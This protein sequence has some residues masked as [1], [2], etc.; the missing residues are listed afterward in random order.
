MKTSPKTDILFVSHQYEI[1]GGGEKALLEMIQYLHKRGL[2]LHVIIG[3]PGS[4]AEELNKINVPHTIIF[5]PFWAHG[6]EDPSPFH[7]TSLNP[8]FN[9]TRQIVALIKQLN[10]RLCVTNTIVV[11]WLAYAS[12][13]TSK[14][15]AW[16]IHELGTAGL[17]LRYAIGE[18][19]T[20]RSIDL[21]S[22]II[23]FNSKYT[24]KYYL[25][26]ISP[27]TQTGIVYPGGNTPMPDT[28]SSPFTNKNAFKLV[29]VGQ[30]K[31]QKGQLD[32]VKA[33]SRL[34]A[35]GKDI[36]I[37]LVG[38]VEDKKYAAEIRRH[39]RKH[40]TEDRVVFAGYHD[41]PASIV[42]LADVAIVSSVNDAF[43]RVTVEAMLGGKPVVAAASAGTLEIITD[44]RTGL[45]YAP[46]DDKDLANKIN[47]L[48]TN[49]KKRAEIA[50]QGQLFAQA[51]YTDTRRYKDFLS[52]FKKLP[53]KTALDLSPLCSS[54]DDFTATVSILDNVQS[55]LAH[56]ESS[57]AWRAL[58]G[59]K[60]V[61][62]GKR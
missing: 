18:S 55:H 59:I 23:F 19:Q 15:H 27:S 22:D 43:G 5:L 13:L 11:P 50:K 12:A 6:G 60:K 16:M 38:K 30:I 14:H 40:K 39:I 54:F 1:V 24:S 62:K 37:A 47:L 7:F 36:Q 45:L 49:P 33:T 4:F 10:P 28:I 29:V 34:A 21:L 42:D 58:R 32:A 46:R 61:V 57:R 26:H 51:T 17:N 41:N 52:Y 20:L 8:A 44:N 53:P 48:I 31:P 56:I 3:S 35:S 2:R 25:P 9:T